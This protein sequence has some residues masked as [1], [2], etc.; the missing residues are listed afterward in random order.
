METVT[1]D[2]CISVDTV[3]YIKWWCFANYTSI[4]VYMI[5]IVLIENKICRA[6]K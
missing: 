6:Q 2:M 5:D 3:I 1:V 4:D